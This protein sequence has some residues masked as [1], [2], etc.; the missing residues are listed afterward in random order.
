V[1]EWFYAEPNDSQHRGPVSTDALRGMFRAGQIKP[2]TL[3]WRQ[4]MPDWLPIEQVIAN[5]E[6]SAPDSPPA[7]ALPSDAAPIQIEAPM[8]IA[9]PAQFEPARQVA[10]LDYSQDRAREDSG[11]R[12]MA[13]LSLIFGII[14]FPMAFCCAIFNLFSIAGLVLGLIARSRPGPH[15]QLA[16]AGAILSAI[17]LVL[18]CG[19]FAVFL[20][21]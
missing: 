18:S 3:V 17:S 16:L 1:S 2:A 5:L 14:S 10:A 19:V 15:Q 8:Q 7:A 13:I 12:V 21:N 4:E 9:T 11:G 6:I 20:I